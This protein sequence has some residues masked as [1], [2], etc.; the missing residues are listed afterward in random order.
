MIMGSL[1]IGMYSPYVPK[2]FGGGEKHFFDVALAFAKQHQVYIA[3]PSDSNQLNEKTVEHIRESYSTFLNRSLKKLKFIACPFGTSAFSLNKLFWTQQFDGF[4]AVTDGSLFFSSAKRNFL[5]I[6]IPFT[7][8]KKRLIDKLKLANWHNKNTNSFFTKSVVEKSWDISIDT[9]LQPMVAVNQLVVKPADLA[10]KKKIILNVG[11][12]FSQLH[13]KRQDTMVL[14]FKTMIERHTELLKGWKLVLIGSVE[15][16]VFARQVARLAQNAPI[17]IHHEVTREELNDWYKDSQIY[18]H[19]TGYGVNSETE[20][21]KVEHFGISTVEAMA[22]GCAPVVINLGGQKEILT[23]QLSQYLW[24]T[25][26]EA[27]ALTTNL[28]KQPRELM[29]AQLM[30]QERAKQFN[31]THFDRTVLDMLE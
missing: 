30:A 13:C 23:D 5:H 1:K 15:D 17:E 14:T 11:R 28:I 3:I 21:E 31:Q 29:N 18:W 7:N 20:P 4:Y 22:A 2:H 9:V 6:Q 10:L 16:R 12:F 25:T 26:D 27:I 24:N 19:A 8:H